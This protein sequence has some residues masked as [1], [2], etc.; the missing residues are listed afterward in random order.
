MPGNGIQLGG[1]CPGERLPHSRRPR[2]SR[3]RSCVGFPEPRL[4]ICFP[5]NILADRL[6][7]LVDQ[8]ILV[9][10]PASDG[11]NFR[12]YVLTPKGEQLYLVLDAPGEH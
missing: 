2:S 4:N 11:T 1:P 7:K 3:P 12:E 5:S 10:A 8:G 9:T 6:R